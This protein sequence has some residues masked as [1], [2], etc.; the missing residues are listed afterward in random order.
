[1]AA[2]YLMH[3]QVGSQAAELLLLPQPVKALFCW[4][5]HKIFRDSEQHC[6]ADFPARQTAPWTRQAVSKFAPAEVLA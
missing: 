2:Q 1:M 3:L 5:L 4:T 6:P